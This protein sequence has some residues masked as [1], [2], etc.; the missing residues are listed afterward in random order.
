MAME[1]G[2]LDQAD[3]DCVKIAFLKAQQIK[4][5]MDAGFLREQDYLQA[6]DSFLQSL[7][8]TVSG[9]GARPVAGAQPAAN[10]TAS[11]WQRNQ[12]AATAPAPAVT[13]AAPAP[14]PVAAAPT[15]APAPPAARASAAPASSAS[16]ANVGGSGGAIPIPVNLAKLGRMGAWAGKMSMSG[17]AINDDSVNL[18]NHMK[19]RSSVVMDCVG[20]SDASYDSFV[21]S[22]PE[23]ECRYGVFDYAYANADTQQTI[24]KL[25]FVN[26]APEGSSTKAKMMYASTKDF[27]KGYLDGIGAELQAN[28][29]SELTLDEMQERV[30]LS[31]TRK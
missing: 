13:R 29:F 15:P 10:K 21:G 7:D 17:I 6:R 3:F 1:E 28:E 14:V 9:G 8:F 30:H 18:F 25:V 20:A 27:F 23:S 5:G 12:P 4:A 2:L 26:W 22:F 11:S 16:T 31:L 19:S 24:N